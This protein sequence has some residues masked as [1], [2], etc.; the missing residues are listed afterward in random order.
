VKKSILFLSTYNCQPLSCTTHIWNILYRW[1]Y[2]VS[3]L[4]A[5]RQK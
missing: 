5:T 1:T 4:R 3:L 2:Y